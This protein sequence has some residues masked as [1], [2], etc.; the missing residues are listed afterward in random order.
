MNILLVKCEDPNR[1][2]LARGST[3]RREA[4]SKK[5]ERPIFSQY[6]LNEDLLH[7]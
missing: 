4:H 6:G 5:D 2:I 3:N 1:R 7:E